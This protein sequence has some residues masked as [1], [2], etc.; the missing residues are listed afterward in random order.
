MNKQ[1]ILKVIAC[2]L[3]PL[4][5]MVACKEH[6]P[7]PHHVAQPK[8]AQPVHLNGVENMHQISDELYRSGQPEKEGF[9]ELERHGIR[10]VLNLRE[11]HKDTKKAAHTKLHLVAY[12]MAAGEVTVKDIENC[13]RIIESSPKPVLVHCWHGSDRT[14]IIV[15]AYRIVY[16]GWSVDEAEKEFRDDTY[17]HHEFWYKN[18]VSLLRHTDWE[19]VK[20]RLREPRP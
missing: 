12:P 20:K 13:L 11:Y 6:S 4:A 19:A 7:V 9:T 15:A 5:G 14:G 10:T 8:H 18:L 16:E 1:G 17:G 2:V 3:L